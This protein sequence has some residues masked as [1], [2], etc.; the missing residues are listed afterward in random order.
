M[1]IRINLLPLRQVKK[2]EANRQ[3]LLVLAGLAVLGVVGNGLWYAARSSE[4]DRLNN[5]VAITQSKIQALDKVIG[6]VNRLNAKKKELETKLKTLD[7]LRK[8]R[9]GPVKF[10]DALATAVPKTVGIK[11]FEE[12]ASAVKLTGVA[13]SHEDVADL[14]RGLSSMVWTPKGIGR[15]MEQKKD[16][17]TSRVELL[18][19]GGQVED[20]PVAQVSSFFTEVELRRAEQKRVNQGNAPG[21]T[22]VDF[23][24]SFKAHYAI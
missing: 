13:F 6:E 9:T 10:M 17:P 22:V 2:R 14:M 15:L 8:A 11:A 12:H 24:L 1:M 21:S 18:A 23:E 19:Q 20:F 7:E 3:W 5:E 4:L 16:S